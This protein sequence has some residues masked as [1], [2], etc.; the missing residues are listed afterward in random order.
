MKSAAVATSS[1]RRGPCSE[2]PRP[3]PHQHGGAGRGGPE[4]GTRGHGPC[5]EEEATARARFS[6]VV[7]AA[8]F[9][10]AVSAAWSGR[11]CRAPADASLAGGRRPRDQGGAPR[12]ARLLIT[13]RYQTRPCPARSPRR[14]AV[15]VTVVTYSVVAGS[16]PSATT[17]RGAGHGGTAN[18]RARRRTGARATVRPGAGHV[19]PSR[20]A[21]GVRRGWIGTGRLTKR[22]GLISSRIASFWG[23]AA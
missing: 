3:A 14:F 5:S 8:A 10:I 22:S 2:G 15:Y 4:P 6:V 11:A 18:R 20:A 9:P 12:F 16:T 7:I 19:G 1:Q 23:R 13:R 17:P 21:R